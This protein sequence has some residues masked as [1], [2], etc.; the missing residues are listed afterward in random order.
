M[1]TQK[2]LRQQ[3]DKWLERA[4]GDLL[5][6]RVI[7]EKGGYIPNVGFLAQQGAEKYLKGYLTYHG[8]RFRKVHDL[9]EL[10]NACISVDAELARVTDECKL[11]NPLYIETRYPGDWPLL[12]IEEAT[13][14]I[15]AA[16]HIRRLVR[17]KLGLES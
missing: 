8:Q 16:R 3:A 10:L 6:A 11:L 4:E 12:T 15:E 2:N 1:T 14:A 17:T 9:L 5:S 13:E 7:L